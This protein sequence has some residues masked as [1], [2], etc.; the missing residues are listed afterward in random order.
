MMLPILCLR[1]VPA[2]GTFTRTKPW[3][4]RPLHPGI[5]RRDL[6]DRFRRCDGR[7]RLIVLATPR[8]CG[9]GRRTSAPPRLRAPAS[10]RAGARNARI[11]LVC[12]CVSRVLDR[13][14]S[15]SRRGPRRVADV[16]DQSVV[17]GKH[18]AHKS[19]SRRSLPHAGEGLL[20]TPSRS[21]HQRS[22]RTSASPR[23]RSLASCRSG[24]RSSS[25][26]ATTSPTAPSRATPLG[27]SRSRSRTNF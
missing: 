24:H 1:Y 4:S 2:P 5:Q 26:P 21:R 12:A 20:L 23:W 22:D 11:G 27:Q 7:C 15:D 16:L 25:E 17:V 10:P 14:T 19:S 3:P 8:S 13:A 6:H 9:S 18:R